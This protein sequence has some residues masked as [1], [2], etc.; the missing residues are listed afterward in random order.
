MNIFK[1]IS[2]FNK[3]KKEEGDDDRLMYKNDD[4]MND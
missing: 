2:L 1:K 3:E 4:F